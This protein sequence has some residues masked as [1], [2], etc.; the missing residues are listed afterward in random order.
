[1]ESYFIKNSSIACGFDSSRFQF[2]PFRSDDRGR[3]ILFS[4]NWEIHV[5]RDSN[6]GCG[7]IECASFL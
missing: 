3:D 4:W 5:L 1:M 7:I 2:S 6:Y